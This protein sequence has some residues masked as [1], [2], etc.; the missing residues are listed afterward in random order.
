MSKGYTIE[1][2]EVPKRGGRAAGSI[3][4]DAVNDFIAQHAQSAMV[5][6]EG[7]KTATTVLQL[8]KAVKSLG[9]SVGVVQRS[10][11]VYLVKD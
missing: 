7:R 2:A 10:G 1:A 8:R 3:Y 5:T 11:S 6:F 4:K 9:V